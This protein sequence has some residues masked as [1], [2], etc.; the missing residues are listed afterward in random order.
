MIKKLLIVLGTLAVGAMA[1]LTFA[2][3]TVVDLDLWGLIAMGRETLLR[4]WPPTQDPF[5]YVPT[6]DPVVYHEWLSGVIFYLLLQQFGSAAL[7][8]LLILLG[9]LTLC[10]AA[11][12]GR[13]RGASYF[14]L[15][16]NEPGG[17]V[18]DR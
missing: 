9:I 7:K 12:A 4:G 8:L 2:Q 1:V 16:V 13:R 3:H 15:L 10:F 17:H 5:A 6:L 18:L 14:S 11:L